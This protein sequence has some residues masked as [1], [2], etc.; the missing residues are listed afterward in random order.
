M[1]ALDLGVP[2]AGAIRFLTVCFGVPN[3]EYPDWMKTEITAHDR[4][5]KE[6]HD[7]IVKWQRDGGSE[8]LTVARSNPFTQRRAAGDALAALFA[9]EMRLRTLARKWIAACRVRIA[10]RRIVGA[11]CDLAT[12]APVAPDRSVRVY[13]R[14][15]RRY[16]VFHWNTALQTILRALYYSAYGIADPQPPKNPYTNVSW[17]IGQLT[18]IVSDILKCAGNHGMRV[19]VNLIAYRN[20]Q[21]DIAKYYELHRRTLEIAAAMKFF[22]NILDS[23]VIRIYMEIIDDIIRDIEDDFP[24]TFGIQ[25]VRESILR[26]SLSSELLKKWDQFVVSAWM[27]TNHNMNYGIAGWDDLIARARQLIV[28][29]HISI[30]QNS[31]LTSR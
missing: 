12:C 23:E 10:A 8:P 4:T 3:T 30:I 22:R 9:R 21:F 1:A 18:H 13:D 17:N 20:T 14:A 24:Y 15:S 19:H 11:D 27:F 25:E 26:R 7:L 28:D 2:T 16:Y 5:Y 29:S 31:V 6:W